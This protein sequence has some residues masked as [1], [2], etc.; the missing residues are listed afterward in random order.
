[1]VAITSLCP[2]RCRPA[3]PRVYLEIT[4]NTRIPCTSDHYVEKGRGLTRV[5]GVA[6]LSYHIGKRRGQNLSQ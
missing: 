6:R 2:D 1:M 5:L 4:E 3:V